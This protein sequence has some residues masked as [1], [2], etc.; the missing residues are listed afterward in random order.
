[1]RNHLAAIVALAI[2]LSGCQSYGTDRNAA[3]DADL[4]SYAGGTVRAFAAAQPDFRLLETRVADGGR[5]FLFQ[6]EPAL[7]TTTTPAY[8]PPPR[9]YNDPTLGAAFNN[10]NAAVNTVPEVSRTVLIQCRLY[11]L[12]KRRGAGKSLDDWIVQRAEHEGRC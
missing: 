11:V 9:R 2:S 5:I 3:I 6:D 10:L 8:I 7:V 12:A 4:S 1:M